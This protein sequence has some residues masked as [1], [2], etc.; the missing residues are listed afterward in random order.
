MVEQKMGKWK[1]M[2]G[3]KNNEKEK[4]LWRWV[5]QVRANCI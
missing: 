4:R 3:L 1:E 5:H 2:W